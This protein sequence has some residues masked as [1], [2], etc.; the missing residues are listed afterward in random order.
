MVAFQRSDNVFR[1]RPDLAGADDR[2]ELGHRTT[3]DP[4]P[5]VERVPGGDR[6][7]AALTAPPLLVRVGQIPVDERA[8]LRVIGIGRDR[9]VELGL[10]AIDVIRD[11]ERPAHRAAHH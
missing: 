3:Q 9:A 2:Q 1:T 6:R 5:F 11:D 8:E 4:G 7:T 10:D